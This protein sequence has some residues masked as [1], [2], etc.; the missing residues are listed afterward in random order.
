MRIDLFDARMLEPMVLF[1][2]QRGMQA[3]SFL[4]RVRIPREVV[5]EGGW[6]TKRQAYDLA[7]DIV[8]RLRCPEAIFTA[9]D[10]FELDHLGP[11]ADA[12]RSCKTVKE[13]LEV[14][15]RLGST[16]Y[17]GNQYF[18]RTEGDT[19]WFCY[20]EPNVVSAGQ[21]FINDMTMMVYYRL[22]RSAAACEWRPQQ[23]LIRNE[24]IG[25]H[26]TVTNFEN[27]RVDP[28]PEFSALAFPTKL[29]SQRSAWW[30]DAPVAV[31]T[32][33]WEIPPEDN[34]HIVDAL[35]RLLLSCFPIHKLPTLDQL[36][37][38]V[39]VSPATLKR[40]LAATC[41][42]Y[43]QLLDRIRFDAACKMLTTTQLSIKEIT[44]ELGYSGTNNFVRGFRRMTGLTPGQ[45][46]QQALTEG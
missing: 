16:A 2:E 35:S 26:R 41:T 34:P 23:M 3:E 11:V 44:H 43:R 29:L 36:A 21:T 45:Y 13:A 38:M 12:M 17:E 24:I 9:Y 37:V 25:R 31:E 30:N 32:V 4:D 5:A 6:I 28:H 15:A 39:D 40:Q 22:I 42:T 18:L 7:Y 8:D 46:R 1:L 10:G 19:T 33:D 14:G 27:C 20:R